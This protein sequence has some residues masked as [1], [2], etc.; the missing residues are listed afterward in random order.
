MARPQKALEEHEIAT[1]LPAKELAARKA[2][3][4]AP[5][6]E[7]TE[8]ELADLDVLIAEARKA[9]HRGQKVRGR[10]NPAFTNLV[11]LMKARDL[12]LKSKRPKSK[13]AAVQAVAARLEEILKEPTNGTNPN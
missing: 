12:L 9:C 2:A 8:A 1:Y 5:L 6:D 4:S 7:S 11:A 10:R 13:K 3:E